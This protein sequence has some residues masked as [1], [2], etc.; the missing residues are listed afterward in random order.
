MTKLIR[1]LAILQVFALAA[2]AQ[3]PAQNWNNVKALTVGTQVRI[4]VGSR[5]VNG[6]LQSVTDDSLAV[7]SGKGQEMFTR[8]EVKQVSTKKMGHRLRNTLLGLGIG[9][10]AGVGTGVAIGHAHDCGT[11]FLCGVNTIAGGALGGAIGLVGGTIIGAV[12]PTGG[13]REVYKQ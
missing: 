8:Q 3:A 7:N 10:G 12:I 9:T 5:T 13:W 6:D 1:A 2:A 11:G 4:A